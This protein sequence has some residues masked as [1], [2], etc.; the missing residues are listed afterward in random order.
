MFTKKNLIFLAGRHTLIAIFVLG[1]TLIA[2]YFLSDAITKTAERVA[3]TRI[4]VHTLEKRTELFTAL[5]HDTEVIGNNNALIEKAFLS[6]G[7]ILEFT[8]ALETL[9]FKHNF[10]QNFQFGTPEASALASPF[11]IA[12]ISY[13]NTL[14]INLTDLIIYLKEFE[15]L[16]YFTKVESLSLSTQ[17]PLG[18]KAT[19]TASFRATF[20]TKNEL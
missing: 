12:T 2:L 16:P 13:T 7:N 20:Y 11:P 17:S 5:R 10:I 4:I 9:A 19:G 8:T 18:W 14:S 1:F 15:R 3:Q 6:S